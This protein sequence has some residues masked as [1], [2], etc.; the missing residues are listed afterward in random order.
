MDTQPIGVLVMAYGTARDFDD[1]ER[2]YTDIRGG[3]APTPEL[4][5]ELQSRYRAIGGHSPLHEITRAQERTLA[6]ELDRRRPHAFRTFL[7]MKHSPP[8]VRDGV[9][10]M[11]EAGISR[12][13]GLVLAPHES[14]LSIGAYEKAARTA[15]GD[16]PDIELAMIRH[17]HLTGAFLDAVARRVSEA[18]RQFPPSSRADV[19]VLFTAH[20]LPR[21]ILDDGDPYPGQ[22][23]ESATAIAQKLGLSQV[24]TAYQS[25]GRTQDPWLGPDV[26]D[27][28]RDL[29]K[30]GHRQVVICAQGFV[31]DHLEVLY[32]LDVECQDVCRELGVKMVRTASLNADPD[33]VAAL[34]DSVEA[35]A[36]QVWP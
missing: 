16:K 25:A 32:D 31:S 29:A 26:C 21:R 5:A 19:P 18:L 22:L 34:A 11:R 33:F 23:Q 35:K 20:S 2:Y 4:L 36:A 1:I 13:I 8:F 17:W 6:E 7:G 9:A 14:R 12:A 15:L 27:A 24:R 3:R 10:E 30:A 28:V